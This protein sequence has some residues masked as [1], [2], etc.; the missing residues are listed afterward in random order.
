MGPEQVVELLNRYLSFA[1][2]AVLNQEGTLDKYTG[3]G[4]MALF[5]APL[6]QPDHALRAAR[7]AL[8]LR[9]TVSG[10]VESVQNRLKIQFGIGIDLG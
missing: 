1:G 4:L 7:A 9:D 3:D 6:P 10:Y 8:D 2:E 5:N